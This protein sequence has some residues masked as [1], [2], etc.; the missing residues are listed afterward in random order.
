MTTSEICRAAAQIAPRIQLR[1]VWLILKELHGRHLVA[2]LNPRH[3]TGKLYV[4]SDCGRH[5]VQLAFGLH[6]VWPD[7]QVDW[8]RY[9]MVARAKLRKVVLME[10]SRL[11]PEE[12]VTAT[13]VRKRV[14]ARHPVGL[15]PV[16]RALKDLEKLRLVRVRSADGARLRKTYMLTQAGG[17][18]A[19]ALDA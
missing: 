2:C 17:R 7:P 13:V 11:S 14:N 12:P 10:L 19:A 4:L 9:A 5:A 1:D 8:Q 18:I 3:V 16:T 6:S 15:N